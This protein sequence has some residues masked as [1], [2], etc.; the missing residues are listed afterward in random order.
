MR[1]T[2]LV[3]TAILSLA[4][5]TGMHAGTTSDDCVRLE[6]QREQIVQQHTRSARRTACM[7]VCAKCVHASPTVAVSR[8]SV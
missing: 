6:R 2:L 7:H 4:P 8:F 1:Q 5:G 3:F